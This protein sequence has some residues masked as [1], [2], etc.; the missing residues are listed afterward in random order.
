MASRACKALS[1]QVPAPD[2][3][4]KIAS[5]SSSARHFDPSYSKK[6]LRYLFYFK[7]QTKNKKDLG[8][9]HVRP[10]CR[11]RFPLRHQ[12]F[13]GSCQGPLGAQGVLPGVQLLTIGAGDLSA[14]DHVL[15]QQGHRLGQVARTQDD[16]IVAKGQVGT[17]QV[18]R[19]RKAESY[20]GENG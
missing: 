14:P 12:L 3:R 13:I 15:L 20:N 18:L 19:I 2:S 17:G 7:N 5:T 1:A 11:I 8:S 6:L 10:S 16:P 9:G 4:C